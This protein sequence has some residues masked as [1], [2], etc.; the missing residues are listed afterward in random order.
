M[1]T[2]EWLR[3]TNP[4]LLDT[5]TEKR[6]RRQTAEAQTANQR[7]GT[8]RNTCPLLLVADYRFFESMGQGSVSRTTNY[9]VSMPH[10]TQ[11]N[12]SC[13]QHISFDN[14]I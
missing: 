9:L 1:M 14:E 4:V 10:M 5:D 2:Q 3:T 8:Q 12:N 13:S 7:A 6:V 11:I